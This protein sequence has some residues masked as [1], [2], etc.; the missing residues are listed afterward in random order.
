MRGLKRFSVFCEEIFPGLFS[1][2]TSFEMGGGV[3]GWA[4]E[5]SVEGVLWLFLE[6]LEEC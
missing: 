1:F 3:F 2:P 4:L 5:A 6:E